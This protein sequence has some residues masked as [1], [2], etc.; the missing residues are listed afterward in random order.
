MEGVVLLVMEGVVGGVMVAVGVDADSW[1]ARQCVVL[2]CGVAMSSSLSIY[3][4]A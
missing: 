3:R 1:T 2:C 4:E